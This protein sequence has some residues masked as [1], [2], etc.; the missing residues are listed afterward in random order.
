MPLPNTKWSELSTPLSDPVL[1]VIKSFGFKSLT[2]VQGATIPLLMTRKD[3]SAEAVTGSGKTLA[4]LVPLIEILQARHKEQPWKATEIGAIVISPTRELASQISDVLSR[5]TEHEE[6]KIFKQL[7][8]VGG[9]SIEADIRSIE[10]D[11]PIILI[12]TPG[13]LCD[14]LERKG[15]VNL[16]GRVKSLEI[17]ILDEAD[18]LLDLGFKMTINTIL[19]YLPRQRRTGL[20]SATQTKEVTDLMRAGLRNPV[21][22]SVKEKASINTPVRLDNY[23][24]IVEPD[25]KFLAIL[26]FLRDTEIKKGMIFMP[27]CACVDY[28]ADILS[29]FLKSK[30]VLGLHGK[31]KHKRSKIVNRFRNEDNVLLMCT[32]VLARGLDVPEVNW[33]IQWDPPSTPAAFIHRVGRT[34]RQGEAGSSIAFLMPNEDAYV[35]FLHINQKVELQPFEVAELDSSLEE[36]N[37]Q[38][39]RLQLNDRLLYDKAMRAF[40]S[41]IQAY[42][43][44]ECSAILRVKDLNFGKVATSFALLHMPRMPELKKMNAD[45]FVG[46]KFEIDLNKIKYRNKQKEVSRQNKLQVYQETGN[47]PGLKKG[48][49]K[50]EAWELSRKERTDAKEKRAERRAKRKLK[51]QNTTEVKTKKRKQAFSEED[52]AELANDIQMFKKLK[53]KKITEEEFN[54]QMGFDDD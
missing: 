13:R 32:D 50:S 39:Y 31:M 27:T 6:L 14:I 28:W 10:A 45:D 18:R 19:S 46:P 53:K 29:H 1:N 23:Y 25:K 12:S 36:I 43:K 38:I 15:K 54:E 40:V 9:N 48:K 49:K 22:V 51:K 7:L 34:A 41:Y 24:T 16:P 3:V 30:K 47:W 26:A 5:F 21:L 42:S 8:L 20:F 2:P 35:N 37:S 44:H 52:L 33:V 4:F 11:S 17:L